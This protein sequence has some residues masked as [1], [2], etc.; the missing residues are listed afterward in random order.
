MSDQ[1]GLCVDYGPLGDDTD[2]EIQGLKAWSDEC[3][4]NCF[5][6]S[7]ATRFAV[8][9][10]PVL[11]WMKIAISAR[12]ILLEYSFSQTMSEALPVLK[13]VDM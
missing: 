11:H 10:S 13:L 5:F 1:D 9:D 12:M 3:K 4:F 8:M 2:M 7:L 6:K